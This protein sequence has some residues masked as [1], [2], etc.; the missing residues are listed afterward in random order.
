MLCD[1]ELPETPPWACILRFCADGSGVERVTAIIIT[2]IFQAT[3]NVW[4][5]SAISNAP[6]LCTTD[7]GEHI[8]QL[9][10]AG[11]LFCDVAMHVLR[12]F[13]VSEKLRG[14]N[15]WDI[16]ARTTS[17]FNVEVTIDVLRVRF[18]YDETAS[19]N[20]KSGGRRPS[21]KEATL[22]CRIL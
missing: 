9:V 15:H 10:S 6:E 2:R 16:A 4:G 12:G 1:A 17:R 18:A 19:H 11:R 7:N 14:L 13:G 5:I 3:K 8:G 22:S 21:T 20:G